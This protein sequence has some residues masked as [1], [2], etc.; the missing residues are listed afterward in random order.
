MSTK[1]YRPYF[2][3]PELVLL[4]D[5]VSNQSVS[6]PQHA[7]LYNYLYK[8]ISDIQ[9]GLRQ[10]NHTLKPSLAESLELDPPAGDSSSIIPALLEHFNH[11]GFTDLSPAQIR[12]LQEHRYINDLMSPTEERVYEVQNGLAFK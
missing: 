12:I 5:S 4:K 8:F 2:T 10:A 7:G 1:K 9:D 3:L 11:K 6:S